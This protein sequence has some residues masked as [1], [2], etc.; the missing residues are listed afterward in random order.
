MEVAMWDKQQSN[1]VKY[2]YNIMNKKLYELACAFR[3]LWYLMKF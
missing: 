2:W 1:F 3:D